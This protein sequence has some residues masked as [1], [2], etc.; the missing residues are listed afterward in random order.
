[1]SKYIIRLDDAA[2]KMDIEKWNR[3]ERLLDRYSIKP[4]VGIIPNCKDP[5]MDI[6]QKDDN[7]WNKVDSWE[8]K[9]WSIALH[10]YE[11]VYCTKDGGINPVNHR[12]E[13]AGLSIEEQSRKIREGIKIFRSHGID[14][15]IF[16]APS[17]TFDENTIKALKKESNVH[18]ISDT[19]ASK[20]YSKYGMLFVPQQS[21]KVRKIPLNTVTFCYHPNLM[22]NDAFKSLEFF[23]A[24]NYEKFIEFP[25]DQVKRTIGILDILLRKLYFLRRK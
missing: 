10:G 20:P 1:M 6:Y 21:G 24:D 11:H 23:I 16:F 19:I 7:F 3:M 12:S 22:D 17:H 9:G 8:K 18:A 5:M 14:P 15:Q 4:L 2:S 25:L 13:F